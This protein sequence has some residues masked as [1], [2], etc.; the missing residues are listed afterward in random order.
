MNNSL[1][2]VS[3]LML[4]RLHSHHAITINSCFNPD[5]SAR[6][7]GGTPL[8]KGGKRIPYS[9]FR[10]LEELCHELCHGVVAS[11]QLDTLTS[12]KIYR[13]FCAPVGSIGKPAGLVDEQDAEEVLTAATEI[14]VMR[15]IFPRSRVD[16]RIMFSCYRNVESDVPEL[17]VNDRVLSALRQEPAK[18][19]ADTV[20]KY[21][22]L[23]R[24][25]TA[26]TP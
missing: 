10:M 7:F 26:R 17:E 12:D 5:F 23:R 15:H 3:V 25:L 11:M 19:H 16:E 24:L 9:N 1:P 18:K 13:H 4:K 2:V 8:R 6:Y 21:L 22:Y 14:L 20:L